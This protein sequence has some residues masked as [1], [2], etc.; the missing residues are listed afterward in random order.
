MLYPLSYEGEAPRAARAL[1][2]VGVGAVSVYPGRR[3]IHACQKR[4]VVGS[5]ESRRVDGQGGR[6]VI[7]VSNPDR[8]LL[9]CGRGKLRRGR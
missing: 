4:T 8:P 7:V 9:R 5:G 2:A 1:L 3:N 6:L